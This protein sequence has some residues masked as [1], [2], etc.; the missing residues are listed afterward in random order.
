[1][2]LLCSSVDITSS[3]LAWSASCNNIAGYCYSAM[4]GFCF[5]LHWLLETIKVLVPDLASESRPKCEEK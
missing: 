3:L 1:M 2:D 4:D 5:L